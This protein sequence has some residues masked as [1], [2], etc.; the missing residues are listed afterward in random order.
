[1]FLADFA[2]AVTYQQYLIFKN[3]NL[4]IYPKDENR[5]RQLSI[6]DLYD[7]ALQVRAIFDAMLDWADTTDKPA[8]N[9]HQSIDSVVKNLIKQVN[10]L[11]KK[12][13]D[14]S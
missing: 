3:G 2:D 10:M 1:M 4:V 14:L 12:L 9:K 8:E 6:S 5:Q 7:D 11:D 13:E